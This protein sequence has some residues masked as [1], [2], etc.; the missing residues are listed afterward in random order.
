MTLDNLLDRLEALGIERP[1]VM[2]VSAVTG[3]ESVY[4]KRRTENRLSGFEPNVFEQERVQQYLEPW[5]TI[6]GLAIPYSLVPLKTAVQPKAI[7]QVSIMAW[8]WDYHQVIRQ[9]LQSALTDVGAYSIH[10]DSGPLPERSIA[11][12]MGLAKAGRSQLL[13][14]PRYGTGFY[15]AFVLTNLQPSEGALA[16]QGGEKI[17]T[18]ELI[19]AD[20]CKDCRRCQKSCP[21]AALTGESDF[22][23]TKCVSALT[24]KKGK[25]NEWERSLLGSQLYGCDICQLAC[26]ANK[27]LTWQEPSDT[28]F[29]I[30]RQTSNRID[31]S[32]LLMLSQK[33]FLRTYGHM[34]FAWRGVKT[35]KRNA[36]INMGNSHDL[37]WS[38]ILE[39]YLKDYGAQDGAELT[40]IAIWALA[41]LRIVSIN[42]G[43]T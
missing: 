40:E 29:P 31:P 35:M 21:S 17:L 20:C 33:A 15:L 41:Q 2:S 23:G 5:Q 34:G 22:D 8:E 32:G 1:A 11:L 37:Y 14:H 42:P 30:N 36:L 3:Y 19:L 10:V 4:E 27:E 7:S 16:E 26:P 18:S 25:L 28:K 38:G 9:T 39:D 13:I 43:R 12:K 24:Q 6:I